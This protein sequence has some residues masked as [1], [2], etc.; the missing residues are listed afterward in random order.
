MAQ[1]D[2]GTSV[3]YFGFVSIF[4][5]DYVGTGYINDGSTCSISPKRDIQFLPKRG[6]P[7]LQKE[8]FA[9]F[10]SISVI[11]FASIIFLALL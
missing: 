2:G 10:L 7:F 11:F 8:V 1:N 5:A 6:V 3:E 4:S 9:F